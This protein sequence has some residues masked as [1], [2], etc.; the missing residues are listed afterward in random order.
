[1][2]KT[3]NNNV[4]FDDIPFERRY[5]TQRNGYVNIAPHNYYVKNNINIV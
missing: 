4:L 5:C 2:F 3:L 1:M